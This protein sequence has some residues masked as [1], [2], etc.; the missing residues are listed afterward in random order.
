MESFWHSLENK[1]CL[2][3]YVSWKWKS[4]WVL[5]NTVFPNY[6]EGILF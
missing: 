5:G 4:K 3:V 2:C 1:E 6:S